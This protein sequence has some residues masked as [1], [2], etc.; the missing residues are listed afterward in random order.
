MMELIKKT[1]V[2]T[3][4]QLE[5]LSKKDVIDEEEHEV[6]KNVDNSTVEH[7]ISIDQKTD[8]SNMDT[9]SIQT[10]DDMRSRFEKTMKIF[11]FVASYKLILPVY[12]TAAVFNFLLFVI[13]GGYEFSEMEKNNPPIFARDQGGLFTFHTGCRSSWSVI[14]VLVSNVAIFLFLEILALI[15]VAFVDRDTWFI[16]R[17]VFIMVIIQIA[18]AATFFICFAVPIMS[19]LVDY[20]VP[21]GLVWIVE[22][23]LETFINVTL[24]VLYAFIW[25]HRKTKIRQDLIN[26]TA[27]TYFLS[28]RKTFNTFL[29]FCRRSFCVEN[30]LCYEMICLY[31]KSSTIKNRKKLAV[32]I[33]ET[34]LKPGAVLQL[35]WSNVSAIYQEISCT[36][37]SGVILEQS[38]FDEV[39]FVCL[40]NMTDAFERMKAQNAQVKSHITEWMNSHDRSQQVLQV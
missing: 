3:N 30:I 25:D 36:V 10:S 1:N 31:K 27:L 22:N 7:P 2:A 15:L 19:T 20:I 35:N 32:N 38:L 28:K 6:R 16:K 12:I 39:L 8:P 29:D 23:C 13:L 37:E 18:T 40:T 26:H 9:K 33:C 11:S 14:Y 34:F 5:T 24:P 4:A 21:Y 17:E